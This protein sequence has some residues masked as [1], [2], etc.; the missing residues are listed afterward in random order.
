MKIHYFNTLKKLILFLLI[1]LII[2]LPINTPFKFLIILFILPVIFFSYTNI[3]TKYKLSLIIIIIFYIYKFFAPTVSIQE[4]HNIVLMNENS[5]KYYEKE[6]PHEI[7]IFFKDQFRSKYINSTCDIKDSSCWKSYKPNKTSIYANSHDW[8]FENIKYSRVVENIDFFDLTSARIGI[9][10]DLKF[11]FYDNSNNTTLDRD[12][13]PFFIMY[14]IP[15]ELI[16]S[17]IC[18]K[19]EIFWE[20]NNGKY[21]HYINKINK[22]KTFISDDVGKRIYLPSVSNN[23]K[24]KL[25]KNLYLNIFKYLNI[26]VLLLTIFFILF[27]NLKFNYK[28]YLFSFIYLFSYIFLLLFINKQLF[29]GFDIFPGGMDGMVYMTYGNIIYEHLINYNFF[30]AF[31]GGESVFYFPSSLRYFW[32]L[33]KFFFGET[34]YGYLLIPFFY[35][36]LIFYIL[37]YLIGTKWALSITFINFFSNVFDGYALPNMKMINHI[38]VGHAEPLAIFFLL[39]GLVLMLFLLNSK[40]FRVSRFYNF[41]FGFVLFLAASLRPNYL[42]TAFLMTFFYILYNFYNYRKLNSSLF[43]IIGFSLML[44]I[45]LHNYV[46]GNSY[47]LLSSGHAYNTGVPLKVYYNFI[48]DLFSFRIN[49]NSSLIINQIE[50]WIKPKDLHYIFSIIVILFLVFKKN[51]YY[52]KIICFLALSQHLVLLIYEPEHRY[53]YLAWIL[54]ILLNIYFIKIYIVDKVYL[55]IKN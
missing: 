12:N 34:F 32:A 7:F 10:N 54:T 1:I 31:E 51:Y 2:G 27:L 26:L 49:E 40:I 23:L 37:K 19:G 13:F 29:Y 18:W 28:V 42:P 4:G 25:K 20:K 46:Y 35:S 44:L 50:R 24:V 11:N 9:V 22:C 39:L 43:S 47:V 17:S 33:S 53:A 16:N 41:L 3:N 38:N 52:V 8:S 36:G 14:E 48:M 45:P 6:L 21:K 30:N 15:N 55:K 5:Y